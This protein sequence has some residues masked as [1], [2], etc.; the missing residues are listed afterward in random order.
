[1]K[2]IDHFTGYG[3]N[4]EEVW[5]RISQLEENSVFTIRS[6]LSQEELN[7]ITRLQL[8]YTNNDIQFDIRVMD[9]SITENPQTMAITEIKPGH[10]MKKVPVFDF[11]ANLFNQDTPIQTLFQYVLKAIKHDI[12]NTDR[13]KLCDIFPGY[14]WSRFSQSQKATLGE[15]LERYNYI[16]RAYFAK[17][18]V[19]AQKQN[20]YRG[21]IDRSTGTSE[22]WYDVNVTW[23]TIYNS[24]TK[25]RLEHLMTMRQRDECKENAHWYEIIY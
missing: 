5:K 21:L 6:L 25:I 7:K 13:F 10:Y 9:T 3:S 23:V 22:E 20:I 8:Q 11:N 1:M 4:V 18:G 19:S 12:K 14:V 17:V 24:K 16:G 15:I 2:C